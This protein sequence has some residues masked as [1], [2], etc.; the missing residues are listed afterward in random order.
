MSQFRS[1]CVSSQS[2]S[3]TFPAPPPAPDCWFPIAPLQFW[4]CHGFVYI[5][6]KTHFLQ[7]LYIVS[8]FWKLIKNGPRCFTNGC[9][10]PKLSCDTS[11]CSTRAQK[12][13]LKQ[14]HSPLGAGMLGDHL[15]LKLNVSFS[16]RVRSNLRSNCVQVVDALLV[17]D[18]HP[19]VGQV[20]HQPL[21]DLNNV[22]TISDIE[23]EH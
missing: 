12:Y 2:V 15:K 13:K 23:A 6:F 11:R 16:W 20:E 18:H 8:F 21:L 22:T 17:H 14:T 4:N 1:F 19:K 5:G 7:R 10:D 3:L 9:K